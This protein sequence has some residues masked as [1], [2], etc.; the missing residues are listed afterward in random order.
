MLE[1]HLLLQPA[2]S[3]VLAAR[4]T[5]AGYL[6]FVMVAAG[7]LVT[8]IGA[9]DLLSRAAGVV[10]GKDAAVAA[11]APAITA[12]N[13]SALDS[14]SRSPASA[15]PITPA[16]LTIPALGVTAAVERVGKKADGTMAAPTT[17]G[18]VAWYA[19]GARPG[20]T[21][22]AV[23]AG[24]VNNAL[25]SAG[26]FE[27]LS[28]IK[29]GDTVTV[30]DASGKTLDYFVAKIDEY[31]ADQAPAATVFATEGPSQLVLI[32]CDGDWVASAHSFSKRLVVYAR[33]SAR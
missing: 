15:T 17:F 21:G 32:T 14:F 13:P 26:V 22:N 25:T 24:H 30:A 3:G 20:E 8:L 1:K 10:L 29:I 27:H 28:D 16:V 4:R 19:L 5:R 6:R 11:F 33:L 12:T 2:K 23:I 18:D 9:A 7:I 31:A